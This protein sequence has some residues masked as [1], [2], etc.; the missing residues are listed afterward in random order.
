[1]KP[2]ANFCVLVSSHTKCPGTPELGGFMAFLS[3]YFCLF[4]YYR[5]EYVNLNFNFHMKIMS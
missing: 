5:I 3:V 2:I 4:S 1:M